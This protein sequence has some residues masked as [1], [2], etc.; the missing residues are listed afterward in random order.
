MRKILSL[1]L[2][3]P[4]LSFMPLQAAD[5]LEEIDKHIRTAFAENFPDVKIDAIAETKLTDLYEV[6]FGANIVY[7]DG[8]GH[9]L[10]NGNLLDLQTGEAVTVQ[11]MRNLKATMLA[12]LDEKEMIVY[13]N[14]DA[15]HTI[16]VFTDIDC[17]YCRKL[18]NEMDQYIAQGIRVRYLAF[19]R[20]GVPS[21][22]AKVAESVWCAE[23]R[24]Q[25]MTTAKQGGEVE[26]KTCENPVAKHYQLGQQFSVRG[27][28]ALFLEDGE[29]LA[30]YVPA[31][32]LKLILQQR[33]AT[34]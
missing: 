9:Y 1:L 5:S 28:P 2:L 20:A 12:K 19:P 8:K 26:A 27:T 11:R 21:E 16:T 15:E 4:S 33:T 23:D 3:V 29:L 34:R 25:A 22:S 10:F 24:N 31:E 17:G 14:K 18:H 32:R 30:G 6:T 7:V 13:G